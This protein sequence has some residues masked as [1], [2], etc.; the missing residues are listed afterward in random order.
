MTAHDDLTEI[1][2][3]LVSLDEDLALLDTD[4]LS[5]RKRVEELIQSDDSTH[6]VMAKDAVVLIENKQSFCLKQRHLLLKERTPLVA[7]VSRLDAEAYSK[8]Q[9]GLRARLSARNE[10]L[11]ER[12]NEDLAMYLATK[13]FI[14]GNFPA[15]ISLDKCFSGTKKAAEPIFTQHK[16]YGVVK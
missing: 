1:D 10:K 7:I 14:E 15:R 9:V 6:Y 8:A 4:L 5:A 11:W 2:N 3:R 13:A 16:A 12:L